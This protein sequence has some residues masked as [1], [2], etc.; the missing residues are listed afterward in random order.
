MLSWFSSKHVPSIN[1]YTHTHIYIRI[2]KLCN[3]YIVG[4]MFCRKARSIAI[5]LQNLI[6]RELWV[7]ISLEGLSSFFYLSIYLPI[8]G[9]SFS[10]WNE[11]LIWHWCLICEHQCDKRPAAFS[12]ENILPLPKS[13][14]TENDYEYIEEKKREMKMLRMDNSWSNI[15]FTVCHIRHFEGKTVY[16]MFLH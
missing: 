7:F 16:L 12:I 8:H 4:W 3:Q 10:S 9:F 15:V 1:T 14:F 11:R 13:I 6:H 2:G 5:Q